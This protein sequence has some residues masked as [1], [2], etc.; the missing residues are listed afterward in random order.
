MIDLV[1]FIGTAVPRMAAPFFPDILWRVST[2]ERVLYITFDDGPTDGVTQPLLDVLARFDARAVWFMLGAHATQHPALVHAIMEAG[3]A[4]GNH[5]FSHPSGWS[6]PPARMEAEFIRTTALLEDLTQQPLRFLRPPYGHFT[7]P[8]RRWCLERRQCC[9]MW[10]IGP[11]DYLSSA[12]PDVIARRV[13]RAV[14]PGSVLV[15]HDHP[16]T[17]KVTPAALARVLTYL[18]TEGWRFDAL[19]PAH[20]DLAS[21]RGAYAISGTA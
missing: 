12:T 3:H 19:S 18:Y 11:G 17:K 21:E 6:T 8:M 20:H 10:D 7:G 9:T 16:N 15:L 2:Q 14:R 4:V 1:H 13:L 5:S